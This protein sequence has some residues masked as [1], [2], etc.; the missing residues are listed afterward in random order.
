MTKYLLGVTIRATGEAAEGFLSNPAGALILGGG[1]LA[2][3]APVVGV[4]RAKAVLDMFTDLQGVFDAPSEAARA[5][6]G[7]DLIESMRA[8]LRAFLP[9]RVPL[10]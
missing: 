9:P 8:L 7:D 10:P 4:D 6:S 5:K 2:V 3:L 1:I